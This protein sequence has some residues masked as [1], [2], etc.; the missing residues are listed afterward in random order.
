MEIVVMG[1][2][3]FSVFC[4]RTHSYTSHKPCC[5]CKAFVKLHQILKFEFRL[6]T[7]FTH[8]SYSACLICSW[9]TKKKAL[10]AIKEQQKIMSC[11][12]ECLILL[13]R[14]H[15]AS[16]AFQRLPNGPEI[17]STRWWVQSQTSGRQQHRGLCETKQPTSCS[18][19]PG[20]SFFGCSSVWTGLGWAGAWR[21]QPEATRASKH[22]R[23]PTVTY[24]H[25]Y[26]V[27]LWSC[28]LSSSY[29]Y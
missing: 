23:L 12:E 16:F 10:T 9:R 28:T 4:P 29:W 15:T 13:N 7:P 1:M 22:R 24:I 3:I 14:H 2:I 18:V 17:L 26:T 6:L 8:S 5:S 11:I 21:E 19:E 27:A 25:M 20:R